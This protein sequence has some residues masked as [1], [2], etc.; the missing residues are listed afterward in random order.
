MGAR[1]KLTLRTIPWFWPAKGVLFAAAWLVLSYPQ[2]IL[3]AGLL[4]AWPWFP[5]RGT[6]LPFVVLLYL[7][8]L[9]SPNWWGAII[10]GGAFG[11]ILGIKNLR[12]VERAAAFEGLVYLVA[13]LLGLNFFAAFARPAAPA[14]AAAAALVAAVLGV[15]LERLARL[16]APAADGPDGPPAIN[17]QPVPA[18]YLAAVLAWVFF[19]ALLTF[20][21]LPLNFFYQNA[22]FFLAYAITA[23]LYGSY[24]QAGLNRRFVLG[25]F[26]VYFA[27]AVL[28]LAANTW[29]V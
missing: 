15:F 5:P 18:S 17:T 22:L 7:A 19:T 14:A 9:I 27:G 1:L 28:I 8:G 25:A 13:F 3:L 21:F 4:Y 20:L 24:L 10:L 26:S 6:L 2:F 23:R 11:L 16:Q 12:L 29:T